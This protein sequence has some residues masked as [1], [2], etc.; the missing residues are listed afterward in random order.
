MAKILLLDDSRAVRKMAK[1]LLERACHDVTVVGEWAELVRSLNHSTS[2]FDL[3]LM[4]VELPGQR[5]GDLFTSWLRSS[6]ALDATKIMLFSSLPKAHLEGLAV[7]VGA[8][9]VIPKSEGPRYFIAEVERTL[10]EARQSSIPDFW[11]GM[12]I[13]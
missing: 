8:D 6:E 12:A 3:I 4:D 7:Q 10:E 11:P 5:G 13:A 9:G 2:P 1:R